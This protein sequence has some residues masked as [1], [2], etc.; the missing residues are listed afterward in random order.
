MVKRISETL[1]FH[2]LAFLFF[3]SMH[4]NDFH[5]W[6]CCFIQTL[7]GWAFAVELGPGREKPRIV[8]IVCIISPRTELISSYLSFSYL[9]T[10]DL[11]RVW[12]DCSDFERSAFSNVRLLIL[13]VHPKVFHFSFWKKWHHSS[14]R[15]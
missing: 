12:R 10:T 14:S 11:W 4:Q 13:K 5:C 2:L 9:E 1:P 8:M 6:F 15:F 3:F 7:S